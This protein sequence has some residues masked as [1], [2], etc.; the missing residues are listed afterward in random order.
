MADGEQLRRGPR[1]SSSRRSRRRSGSSQPL[2]AIRPEREPR[3]H[4]VA[5][6]AAL[7]IP[8]DG[9]APHELVREARAAFLPGTIATV[10]S[11][12]HMLVAMA[13]WLVERP[14]EVL[15]SS[16]FATMG[17]ALPGAVGAAIATGRRSSASRATAASGWRSPSSRRS[18]GSGSR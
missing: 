11:G 2:E 6:L 16:G 12:A 9:L 10:D 4:L 17:F 15:I 8:A 14:G 7:D 5:A 18:R 13:Y 3:E 1:S